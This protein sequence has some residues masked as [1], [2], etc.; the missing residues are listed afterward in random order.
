LTRKKEEGTKKGGEG[1]KRKR[2]SRKEKEGK[3]IGKDEVEKR[4]KGR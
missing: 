3:E 2:K 1:K 4:G